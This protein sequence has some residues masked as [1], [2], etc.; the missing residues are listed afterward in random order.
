MMIHIHTKSQAP[1]GPDKDRV[2]ELVAEKLRRFGER[3]TRVEVHFSDENSSA[4]SGPNDQ[5]CLIEVRLAGKNPISVTDHHSSAEQ[6]FRGA[7]VKMQHLIE[8]T[9]R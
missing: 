1:T 4:K 2:Q 7:I 3:I 6:A 5:R 9:L 8:S